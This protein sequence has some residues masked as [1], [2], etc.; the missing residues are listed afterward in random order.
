[1]A[2]RP[3]VMV[4]AGLSS[5]CWRRSCSR[6][7]VRPRAT[8]KEVDEVAAAAAAAPAGVRAGAG[9]GGEV[10]FFSARS[11]S[12]LLM[13][14]AAL[15][16]AAGPGPSRPDPVLGGQIWTPGCRICLGGRRRLQ[17]RRRWP[18]PMHALGVLSSLPS[19]PSWPWLSRLR[20]WLCPGQRP[21]PASLPAVAGLAAKATGRP[22][23]MSAAMV[24]TEASASAGGAEFGAWRPNS[25][26]PGHGAEPDMVGHTAR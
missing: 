4:A 12:P 24:K 9:D 7:A 16:E 3:A 19:L 2:A 10:F 17:R 11:P 14:A 25:A 6:P 1:M 13:A 23:A 22:M 26:A 21:L 20:G 5:S 18:G 8:G 15:A